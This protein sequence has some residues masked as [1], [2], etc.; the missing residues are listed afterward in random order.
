VDPYF[1]N[2]NE[3][4]NSVDPYFGNQ[5]Q[6]GQP[7]ETAPAPQSY[8]GD[9][10]DT[11]FANEFD[12]E[13][14]IDGT[15]FA[16]L[17]LELLINFDGQSSIQQFMITN[18]LILGRGADCDVD[19]VLKSQKE[20]RKETSRKHCYLVLRP[21]GLFVKDNSK[22]KTYLNGNE[23]VGEMLVRNQDMLQLGRATVKV[24]ILT[25]N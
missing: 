22:N 13:A 5:N 12:D 24:R 19:V 6:Y 4:Q 20:E 8:F 11:M 1:G 9:D 25:E 17:K 2:Q 3:N 16:G 23:V 18:Q 15:A 14:T 21:E 7:Q 10:E